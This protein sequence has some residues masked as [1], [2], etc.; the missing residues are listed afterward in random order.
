MKDARAVTAGVAVAFLVGLG[1]TACAPKVARRQTDIMENVGKVSVSGAV[2]R[3]RVNDLVDRF[4]GRIEETADR[5]D[6]ETSTVAGRRRGVA[7]KVD[8]IPAVYTAGYRADPLAAAIDVW[9]LAFQ[10]DAYVNTGPA[11]DAFG[12]RQDLV[13][14]TGRHMIEDADTVVRSIVIRPEHF[15]QARSRVEIWARAHPIAHTFGSRASSASVL[16]ELRSDQ[17][18]AFQAV[19]SVSDTVENLSERLNTYAMQ[20]PKQARWHSEILASELAA[21]MAAALA[22]DRTLGDVHDVGAAARSASEVLKDLSR[23]FDVEREI[24]ETERRSVLAGIDQQ[25]LESLGFVTAERH[26]LVAAARDERLALVAALRQERIEAIAEVDA[27]KTRAIVASLAGLKDLV[28]YAF[29]RVAVLLASLVCLAAVF[30][31]L[32]LALV[33]RRARVPVTP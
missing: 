20:L 2:L 27:I 1:T 29:W 13:Q 19:G 14:A 11:R 16:A 5:I 3:G 26:A 28:D 6:G 4:A 10:F 17:Q 9:V 18:D 8:V 32:A 15:D 31:A 23:L 25:R 22:L 12:P 21:E 33:V 7:L 30:A 24:L